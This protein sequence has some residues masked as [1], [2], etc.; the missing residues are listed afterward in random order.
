MN[1]AMKCFN[2]FKTIMGHKYYVFLEARE[3]GIPWRGFMHD[4]SKLRPSEFFPSARY[5]TGK[6]SPVAA[7]CEDIGYS[8]TWRYHK[9]RNKHHWQ[10]WHDLDGS[11]ENG[12]PK[13]N[14]APMPEKYIR[15][16]VADMFAAAR[17]YGNINYKDAARD[18]YERNKGEWS[19]HP[20]TE[21]RF[22]ELFYAGTVTTAYVRGY[23][24]VKEV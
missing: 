22:L 1:Y 10:W 4:W 3:L 14:P 7:E 19:L 18:Y 8:L 20:E 13:H 11:D 12:D 2:H 23:K 5:W 24:D 21:T 17:A 15:E 16:M 9:G 6:G